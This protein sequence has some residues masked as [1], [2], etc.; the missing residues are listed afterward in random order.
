MGGTVFVLGAG[1]S[2][3]DTLQ[4]HSGYPDTTSAPPPNPPLTNQFFDADYLHGQPDEVEKDYS[5]LVAHIR[6]H[7]GI[8]GPL[9]GPS[10]GSLSIEEVFTSL[11]LL[12]EF[13]PA[14]TNEKAISQLLLNDLN[15][16]VRRSIGRSTLFRFGTNTRSLAQHLKP[17]D[18]V[19]SFN[20]DLLMDQ[21]LLN[22]G[23]SPLQYQNF[24]AK[25]LGTD[26]LDVGNSY[27]EIR[28]TLTDAV[29][30]GTSSGPTAPPYGLYVKL[31]GSLNW[32]VCPN[33][34]CP[35]SKSFVVVSSV[36]QC[37]GSS[38]FG[39]DFQCNYCHSGLIPFLVPPLVQK[40]VMDIPQ[41]RN[42]WGNAF[43]LLANASKIVVIGFSFQ[44]SDFYAAWLFR[45]ALKYTKHAKVWVV[46]PQNSQ[47]EFRD[48]MKSIFA[49]RYDGSY[50]SFDHINDVIRAL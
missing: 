25:L 45:Y 35:R 24:C 26:L 5:H 28:E 43:A 49:S 19:I 39:I 18:S 13:S 21:E 20:Y 31:H 47:P 8:D 17:E 12:N 4:F 10:W 9:G 36:T 34:S 2:H 15:R 22:N 14:G 16:Y 46:N 44:P 42:I 41:L 23:S 32:F 38:V 50:S 6:S 29:S 30:P 27:R 7:W 48:R 33:G 37:L 40:P 1:A 3:G 11:A